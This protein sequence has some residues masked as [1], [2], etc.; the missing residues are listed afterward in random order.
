MISSPSCPGQCVI[1]VGGL[2]TRLGEHVRETPKP[3]LDVGGRPFLLYLMAQAARHGFASFLL[4][5]GYQADALRDY[6]LCDEWRLLLSECEAV[7]NA[8]VEILVETEPLGT[9]GA[10]K[11]A[12]PHLHETFLLMNGDSY[13]QCDIGAVCRPFGKPSAVARM[14]LR[15]VPDCGRYGKVELVNGCVSEFHEKGE[16]SGPGLINAGVYCLRKE[17]AGM[18]P[19][20]KSSLESD[21]FPFLSRTGRLEGMDVGN[22]CFIDIGIPEDLKRARS[23]APD[24]FEERAST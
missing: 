24:A 6:F 1:L 7:R 21:L 12:A 10:L 9:G 23:I 3:M 15:R 19:S 16:V 8:Q 4:L 18:L 20:G 22:G 13:C 2:G 5:A 17:A 11:A 14:A